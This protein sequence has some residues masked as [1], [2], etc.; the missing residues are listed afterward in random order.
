MANVLTNLAA[1]LYKAADTV[2]REL[3]GV[4]SS[5]MINA[6]GSERVALNDVVRS[7]FTRQVGA[8]DN[9]PSMTIPEGTDQTVD[10][11]TLSITKSRGVQIPWTGEDVRHVNNGTGFETIYG[12][13]TTIEIVDKIKSIYVHLPFFLK[14]GIKNFE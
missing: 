4:I 3:T 6:N 5:S 2:G 14:V 1:D 12:D 13:G 11:K 9:A 8:V 10:S 7:H